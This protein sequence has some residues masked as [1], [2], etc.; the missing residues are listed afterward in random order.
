MSATPH[1]TLF[2]TRGVS[3]QTWAQVGSLEREIAL[4]LRLQQKGVKISFITYGGQADLQYRAQLQGIEILCNRWN[5]PPAWY[6]RLIP[7]LHA[8]VLRRT[9][10]VKTNQTNGAELAWRAARLWGKPFLARCGY[11]WSDL[12]QSSGR[13]AEAAR[14]R[15]I[16]RTI[17]THAQGVIVT[18]PS[19]REY[20]LKNYPVSDARA[21][22][23]PN[24]VLTDLF[25]P[26]G[27]S[28]SPRRICFIG[29][30]S[31]EKNLFALVQSC[32]GLD[33]DMHFVGGGH[34]GSALQEKAR[35]LQVNL[36][37]HGNLPHHQLPEM[38]RHSAL[39]ALVSPHEGHP[40]ALLEAMA[41]GAAVLGA[42][43]PGIREQIVHGETGWLVGT[44]AESIRQGIQH[45][46][47]NPAL[48]EK[49]GRNARQFILEHYSLD[50][51]VELEYSLIQNVT[52]ATR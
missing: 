41:C 49:L 46:L 36:T 30:L 42:D 48:R 9:S 52:G 39:F 19:M 10:L 26:G 33:V 43:L 16:E 44:D 7:L 35:E 14:A 13:Q 11:M 6:E 22:L 50:K 34:L 25:S 4:Y 5:L 29:R 15:S 23:I 8:G 32:A 3:L 51:I 1:L 2:F 45:L 31:E 47:A 40:K 27:M 37:L 12:A 38:I 24:F 17:F 20:V 28:P 21:H 18:T